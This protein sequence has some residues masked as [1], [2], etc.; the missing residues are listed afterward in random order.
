MDSPNVR[1]VAELLML[2]LSL[3]CS[4]TAQQN[5]PW[6]S[7]LCKEHRG[8]CGI[9]VTFNPPL[10][11]LLLVPNEVTVDVP[12]ELGKAS[13]VVV[14]SYPLGTE[15]GDVPSEGFV[16]MYRSHKVGN[17]ARF[18]GEIRKCTDQGSLS[19]D[20]FFKGFE[21]YPMPAGVGGAI[22]CE[23]SCT[24]DVQCP[25]GQRC[26][27]PLGCESKGK[28]IV[29]SGK[30]WCNPGNRCGCDGRP[31]N[32]FCGAQPNT[33]EYTSAPATVTPCP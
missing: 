22:E 25:S 26:G 31:V 15:M 27:F 5:D 12:L 17:Y 14:S 20:V 11:D 29:P 7:K 13:K 16:A 33:G 2:L 21:R 4:A 28:C 8:S 19:V 6:K 18:T 24:T 9:L 32:V 3:G 23:Q 1:C 30:T 10:G